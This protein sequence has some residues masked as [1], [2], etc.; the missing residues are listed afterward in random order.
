MGEQQQQ[1]AAV[2]P[3]RQAINEIVDAR[4][5]ARLKGAEP[6]PREVAV[7]ESIPKFIFDEKF[8]VKQI[9]DKNTTGQVFALIW[10][11][12][13]GKAK[14]PLAVV[15]KALGKIYAA[16]PSKSTIRNSLDDLIKLKVLESE[17]QGSHVYYTVRD[18]FRGRVTLKQ[19]GT[20]SK[21]GSA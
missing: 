2:D 15:A 14:F 4:I 17:S 7:T 9:S 21:T 8:P 13:I 20:T 19:D 10:H 18:D 3:L 5:E 11:E 1:A 6:L 16:G 12:K